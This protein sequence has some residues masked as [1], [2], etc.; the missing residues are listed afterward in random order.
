MASELST[1]A[2]GGAIRGAA[3]FPLDT[4]PIPVALEKEEEGPLC[5]IAA[6]WKAMGFQFWAFHLLQTMAWVR[7]GSLRKAFLVYALGEEPGWDCF[8]QPWPS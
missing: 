5:L 4:S 8:F 7:E 3:A 1:P 6:E 2:R